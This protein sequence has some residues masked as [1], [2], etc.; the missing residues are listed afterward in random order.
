MQMCRGNINIYA[1]ENS[2][3][4]INKRPYYQTR[5]AQYI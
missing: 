1:K 5:I 2:H 3:I 4:L